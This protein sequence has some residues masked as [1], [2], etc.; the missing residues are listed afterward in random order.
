MIT[1]TERAIAD[2]LQRAEAELDVSSWVNEYFAF[3]DCCGAEVG[4][5]GYLKAKQTRQ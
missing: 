3:H 1:E 4:A 5:D 2:R